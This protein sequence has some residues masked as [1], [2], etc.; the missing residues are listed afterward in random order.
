M[1]IREFYIVNSSASDQIG[2]HWFVTLKSFRSNFEVFCSAGQ[3]EELGKILKLNHMQCTVKRL[4]KYDT[5]TCGAFCIF[6]IV[7]RL[8]NFDLSFE[9]CLQEFFTNDL[10]ANERR[11]LTFMSAKKF[12][13]LSE[14]HH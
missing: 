12:A 11:V 10:Q 8:N 6:F 1:K 14:C 5:S 2:E 3:A 9:D 4:Q 13:S 7:T